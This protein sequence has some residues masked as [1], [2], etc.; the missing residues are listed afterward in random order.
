MNQFEKITAARMLL[1]IPEQATLAKIRTSYRKV[2]KR[3]HPD[4]CGKENTDTYKKMTTQIIEAYT[5]ISSYCDQYHISFT[6]EKVDNNTSQE[7]W[8][9]ER[10]GNDPLWAKV[11]PDRT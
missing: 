8:W 5:I 2:I 1:E 10:F 7:D 4:K 9:L 3:W 6:Q 11:K